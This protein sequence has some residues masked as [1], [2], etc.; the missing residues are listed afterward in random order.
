MFNIEWADGLT[1]EW[2]EQNVDLRAARLTG[3]DPR[4]NPPSSQKTAPAQWSAVEGMWRMNRWG[5][6]AVL[7]RVPVLCAEPAEGDWYYALRYPETQVYIQWMREG[8][9]PPPVSLSR[10]DKGHLFYAN[11]RRWLAAREAGISTWLAWYWGPC[12]ETERSC[13]RWWF[14]EFSDHYPA[15]YRY[16]LSVGMNPAKD[17]NKY[18][19]SRLVRAGIATAA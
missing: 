3:E 14:P 5:E 12:H 17:M 13:G 9:M 7:L 15:D 10:H 8:H 11:R 1:R 4:F 16:R 2:V 6:C 19:Y 18:V